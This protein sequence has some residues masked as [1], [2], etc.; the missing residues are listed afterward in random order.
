MKFVI[1]RIA[2]NLLFAADVFILFLVLFESK[3]VIPAWLQSVGRMHPMFLHFPIVILLLAMGME[4]FRFRT[5]LKEQSG[6]LDFTGALLLIGALSAAVTVIM[7]LLLSNESS[8]SGKTVQWHKWMGLG[9]VCIASIVYWSRNAKWYK[10]PTAKILTVLAVLCIIVTG[11][12]GAGI[13]HGEDFISNP[14]LARRASEKPPPDKAIIYADIIQPIFKSRCM[15]CHNPD[16]AKGRLLLDNPEDILKG[17][18][19]G[20]LFIAGHA[21][22]SLIIKRISLPE[23]E[24]KHM[25]LTGKPQLT[26]DEAEL[27]FRWIQSGADFKK[28]WIDLQENDSLKLIAAR[29][30]APPAEEVYDFAAAPEKT[31]A[32]LSNNYRAVYP[33][34]KESPALAVDF[35]NK[36]QYTS[37]AL[38]DL[39]KVKK[40]IVQL[41][42]NKMPVSDADL[43]VVSQ[44]ENL[45]VLNLDFSDIT[46]AGLGQLSSL[47]YLKSLSLSGTRVDRKSI[48]PLLKIKR[49][50]KIVL[51]NT[52]LT[53]AEIAQLQKENKNLRFIAGY[54][55]DEPMHLSPPILVS[56]YSVF[57]DTTHVLLKH[58][59]PGVEIRYTLDGSDPDST[60]SAVFNKELVLNK[61]TVFKAR[62]Y[63]PT[64]LGSDS[65]VHFFYKSAYKPDSIIFI[66]LP[67]DAYK[68]EGD[69]VL[70]DHITGS[71]GYNNGEWLGFRKDMK[72]L[73]QFIKPVSLRSV[74]LHLLKVI[75]SDI[76]PPT[77]V[78][79]WGG[80]DKNHL[81]LLKTI[82]PV[83]A[84][85]GEHPELFL[86]ECKF[87]ATRVRCIKL[88]ALNVKKAPKWGN[89]PK[90]PGWIFMDE[91][92]LN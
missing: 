9:I 14:L 15:T 69:S 13:T 70:S 41:N 80:M 66:S 3:M 32:A 78:E 90:K 45:R 82:R 64:W 10:A 19:S 7:G 60:H 54:Q 86:E 16:K 46:G 55:N 43:K 61:T 89:S 8:Y 6:F 39:L 56:Q 21:D 4:F 58:Q 71:L 5:D 76:Y 62:A 87:P 68:G 52:G 33:L 57:S 72:L 24:E 75:G 25:P 83:P 30:L 67:E 65:I 50:Q 11:H 51:W 91:I 22:S 23:E 63:K 47:Q 12:L 2:G 92:L 59:I 74:G 84:V 73:L 49:L 44:F 36:S 88:V 79:I 53:G 37:K 35:Y 17:G 20:K 81:S 18:K 26:K 85:K 28:K 42:L 38:Q 1:K 27:I 29:F 40:Q 31:V 34:A 77:Q 48:P